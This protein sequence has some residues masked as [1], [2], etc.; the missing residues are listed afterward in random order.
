MSV[1]SSLSPPVQAKRS[2]NIFRQAMLAPYV[3][4]APFYI[5]FITFFLLPCLAAL[6]LSFYKWNGIGN[7]QWLGLRNFQ[8][9]FEDPTFWQA[10]GNTVMY[11]L[12]SLF[13]VVPLALVLAGLLNSKELGMGSIWR[14]IYFTPVVTS[15]VAIALVFSL[16][17]SKD[18]GLINAFFIKIG[19][20]AISWLGDGSW[21]KVSII[22]LLVWRWTG[23]LMIYFLAGMQ[24]IS[25]ELYEA[26]MID[27]A[28]GSQQFMRITVPLLRPVIL[29]VCIIVTTGSLQIFE[30]P[31]I[32]TQ[33]G[34][35][36]AT[37][38]ISQ[39]L[40]TRGLAGLKFGIGSAVG[41]L[42]FVA[43]FGLSALQ[44]RSFGIFQEK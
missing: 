41:L 33:G 20:P 3:F 22:I 13:I 37:L 5:L 35:A 25:Q 12:A 23:Y 40:Y 14:S 10:V 4:T 34:P 27:G 1:L 30:E 6:A 16:L 11:M 32:L 24:S 44:L 31:F 9:L 2:S 21:A 36:N 43:I 28:S 15:S 7:P 38:S 19:L 26:A 8:R 42:M 17:Y 18:Y 29:Y 39:Y